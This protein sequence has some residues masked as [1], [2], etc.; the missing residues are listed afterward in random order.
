M[1][2]KKL[3][4]VI[5]DMDGVILDSERLKANSYAD[6]ILKLSADKYSKAEVVETFKDVVGS[7]RENVV[8]FLI[9]Q[10]PF[11]RFL[12]INA[13]KAKLLE[14]RLSIYNSLISDKKEILKAQH[15]GI[16]EVIKWL[17][18]KGIPVCIATMSQTETATRILESLGL[19]PYI[20][21]LRTRDHVQHPKPSPEIYLNILK[22]ANIASGSAVAVED[23]LSGVKSAVSANIK[24]LVLET[25]MTKKV[26]G[27]LDYVDEGCIFSDEGELVDHL[28]N[29]VDA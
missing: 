9:E 10:F 25:E 3:K 11:G 15:L 19:I 24:T 1:I 21:L 12:D 23:S 26:T 8:D 14:Q 7:S 29:L 2:N 20:S 4:L 18:D 6:A 13:S 17:F 27:Y 22:E 5:F 28:V 16:V